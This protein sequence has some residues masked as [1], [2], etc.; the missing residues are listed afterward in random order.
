MG[1]QIEVWKPIK[2]YEGFYEISNFGR[3]KSHYR[4]HRRCDDPDGIRKIFDV[5]GTVCVVLHSKGRQF[6]VSVAHLVMQAFV[7]PEAPIREFPVVD[8]IDGDIWNN[9]LENLRIHPSQI[10]FF[11]S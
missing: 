11:A 6:D 10:K 1:S 9:R 4:N 8:H 3:V 7:Y 2:G 5:H